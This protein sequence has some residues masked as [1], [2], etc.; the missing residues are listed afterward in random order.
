MSSDYHTPIAFH[1]PIA[2]SVVN[3]PLGELDAT[4]GG[5]LAGDYYFTK[6]RV[7]SASEASAILNVNSTT[8]GFLPPRMTTTQ[9]DAIATPAD[10]LL[11][12]NTTMQAY[13]YYADGDW[14]ILA[15][16]LG[17]LSEIVPPTAL[18]ATASVNLS[19]GSDFQDLIL[20]LR[21]RSTLAA[22]TDVLLVRFNGDNGASNYAWTQLYAAAS[23]NVANDSADDGIDIICPADSATA[24]R[25]LEIAFH[26]LNYNEATNRIAGFY[27][28]VL[29]ENTVY[30]TWGGF[31][32]VGGSGINELEFQVVGGDMNGSYALYGLGAP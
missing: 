9:R 25:F 5:F 10:G 7:G 3:A 18:S 28:G 24:G 11:I 2:S 19:L 30:N 22:N 16:S 14:H 12:W 1:A 4:I 6:L 23:T 29:A 21:I 15:S 27:R 13:N 31:E 26:I 8:K 17:A 20:R 32:W